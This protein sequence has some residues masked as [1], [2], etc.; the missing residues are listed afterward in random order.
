MLIMAR[1]GASTKSLYISEALGRGYM[2]MKYN[3]VKVLLR[4]GACCR[5]GR[6]SCREIS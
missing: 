3:I 6:V 1:V 5:L 2:S 4:A